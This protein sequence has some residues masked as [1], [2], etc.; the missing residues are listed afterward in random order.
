[1]T[2]YATSIGD[3]PD[4]ITSIRMRLQEDFPSF[5]EPD[6]LANFE[7]VQRGLAVPEMEWDLTD[8]HL[9]SG[10]ETVSEDG[11]LT[12]KVTDELTLRAFWRRWRE[13]MGSDQKLEVK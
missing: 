9:D 2:W 10:T 8:R 7:E 12:G 1:M 11:L 5:G 13:L 4:E 3:G 6:D